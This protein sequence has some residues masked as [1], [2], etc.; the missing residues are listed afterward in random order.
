MGTMD[1]YDT[2]YHC[3][4]HPMWMYIQVNQPHVNR[5]WVHAGNSG[6][7]VLF[8]FNYGVCNLTSITMSSFDE[9][10]YKTKQLVCLGLLGQVSYK[11][12]SYVCK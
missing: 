8:G 10:Y 12:I 6:V 5:S 11:T 1:Q 7:F 3:Y 2:F 4:S 9:H